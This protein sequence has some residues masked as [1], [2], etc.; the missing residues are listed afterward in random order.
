MFLLVNIVLC[1]RLNTRRL[2]TENGLIRCNTGKERVCAE[3]FPVA[4][5]L[6]NPAH[7]HHGTKSDVDTFTN[8]FFT[9]RNSARAEQ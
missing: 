2:H 6:G 1:A 5:A 9:H 4:P 7:I 3:A 8:M